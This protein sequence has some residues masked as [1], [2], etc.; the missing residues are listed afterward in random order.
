[1]HTTGQVIEGIA[2]LGSLPCFILVPVQMFQRG[3]TRPGHYLHR[4]RSLLRHRRVGQLIVGWVRS[5]EW[6]LTNVMIVWTVCLCSDGCGRGLC[7]TIGAAA[8]EDRQ[9]TGTSR[10]IPVMSGAISGVR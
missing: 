5:R 7:V 8:T 3:Q 4:A 9:G 1:M 6:D 10:A 2:T